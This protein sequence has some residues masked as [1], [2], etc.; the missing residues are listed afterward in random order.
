MRRPVA[1]FETGLG[2][3]G[4]VVDFEDAEASGSCRDVGRG[5]H[6]GRGEESEDGSEAHD[7]FL[8]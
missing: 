4:G 3:G 1:G 2:G 6:G 7:E 5:S 8:D